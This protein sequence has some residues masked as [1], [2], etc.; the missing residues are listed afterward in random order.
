MLA[1]A[2][3]FRIILRVAAV[4]AAVF[5][6]VRYNAAARRMGTFLTFVSHI[7]PPRDNE[8]INPRFL[9]FQDDII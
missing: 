5:V 7:S 3:E 4:F 2:C 9:R 6:I 1:V 8:K